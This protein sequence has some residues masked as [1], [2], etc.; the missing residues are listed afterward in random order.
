MNNTLLTPEF[1][2]RVR[3]GSLFSTA[4]LPP[5]PLIEEDLCTR[6]MK[7]VEMCPVGALDEEDYP[8][9]LTNKAACLSRNNALS[10]RFISP[11]GI[12]IKVC[13]VGKDREVYGREDS[14]IYT[15]TKNYPLHHRAW[16][17]VR[18]YGGKRED[19]R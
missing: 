9:G 8:E 7:C 17:H 5:D 2:P 16:E 1:G 15:D 3:F 6:C 14:S 18:A 11:C 19:P 12:C 4:V 13:P 10:K